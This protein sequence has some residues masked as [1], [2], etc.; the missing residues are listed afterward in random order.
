MKLSAFRV[1]MY[2]SIIDSGWIKISPL[3]TLVGKNESGKTSLLRALHKLNPFT[4]EPYSLERE[5]PRGHRKQ[6]SRSHVVCRGKFLL[7][8]EEVANLSEIAGQPF[9]IDV[10]EVTRSYA[11]ELEILFPEEFFAERLRPN[12]I[13]DQVTSWPVP[14]EPI[15]EPFRVRIAEL[16]E[17]IKSNARE[18]RFTA[19]QDLAG[20]HRQRLEQAHSPGHPQRPNENNYVSQH[21]AKVREIANK[22]TTLPTDVRRAH[23]YLASRLPTFIYMDDYRT[24]SG[25]A[26]LDQVKQ[27]FDAGN[28]TEE[29]K[30]LVMILKMSGLDLAQEAT[31]ANYVEASQR[32]Q[33]QF[34][35]DDASATLTRDIEGRWKQR[36]YEVEFRADG[37]QFFTFVNDEKDPALIRLEERSKGFQWFFSFD[38]LFMHESQGQFRNCVLLLDE[39]G[40]HL[41]PD[42]Q[43]D[44][45]RRLEHYADAN[46]LIYTTHLPFMIELRHPDRIRAVS[47]TS[48]GTVVTEDLTSSQPEARFTLQAALGMSGSTSYL[49]SDRNLIV[50]GVDDYWIISELSNLLIRSGGQGLPEDVVITAG[51]GASEATYIATLMIGQKLGVVVLFDTDNAGNTEKDRLLKSW[52]TL[53]N[54]SH[55]RV[56]SLGPSVGSTQGEFA[57][58][59]MFPDDYYIGLVRESY[60]KE[61]V[62]AAGELRLQGNGQLCKRV[63]RS[64]QGIGIRFNKGRVAKLLRRS[65]SQMKN[66]NELPEATKAGAERLIAAINAAL[67]PLA[68]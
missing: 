64:L 3:T 54:E 27:R 52:L 42:A 30:S 57:I 63:E 33:R 60:R 47:E 9:P 5:W 65:L 44:L 48:Q 23:E 24:F 14:S 67:P 13:D 19:L 12:Q 4:P 39:P 50:E 66:I 7:D 20:S 37:P 22:L 16:Q 38:L 25:T 56:L 21:E 17:E 55:A 41:H 34:D 6:Q 35:L 32:E 46:T 59:D 45:L 53:Y 62:G 68:Q 40:L 58:E 31:K 36:K 15:G 18:G 51:G 61:L 43:K 1:Q 26:R 10:I 29:D 49:L 8:Y 11:G 2:R 28:P